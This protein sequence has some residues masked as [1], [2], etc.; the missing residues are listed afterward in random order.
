MT[1][2]NEIDKKAYITVNNRKKVREDL[3]II[4]DEEFENEID[5][6]AE[7]NES[8]GHKKG[9]SRRVRKHKN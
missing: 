2:N 7:N 9:N 8:F 5:P 3:G 4:D 6:I 1:V